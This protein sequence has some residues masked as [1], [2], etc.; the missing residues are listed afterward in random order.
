MPWLASSLDA[1]R[2]WPVGYLNLTDD[3]ALVRTD[4]PVANARL[5][6]HI[7]ITD[8]G[9]A[10]RWW[11]DAL[12]ADWVVLPESAGLPESMDEVASRGGMRLLRN[13]RSLPVLSLATHLPDPDQRSKRV[14]EVSQLELAGNSCSAM[15]ATPLDSWLWVSLAP[16]SGWRWRL[17]GRPVKLAQ[18][19]GI[20]Q[21][22]ELSAGSHR[23]EGRYLPPGHLPMTILSGSAVLVILLGMAGNRRRP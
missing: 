12:A 4:A 14:G 22:L 21:Y 5:A 20:V 9:P 19:P 18:G 8:E 16:V 7:A 10:R 23:L 1:R 13:R 17:D 11:L 6:S 2:L 15:V 3:L